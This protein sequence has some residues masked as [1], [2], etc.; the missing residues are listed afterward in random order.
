MAINFPTSLDVLV[1]P[2]PTDYLD[3]VPHDQ[4]HVLANDAIEALEAKL[5]VDSSAVATSI[6]YLVKNSASVDPGHKHSIYIVQA[7]QVVSAG[8]AITAIDGEPITPVTMSGNVT[9]TAAPTIAAGRNGQIVLI[10]NDDTV[11][12]LV[13]SDT[14]VLAG[15]LLRLGATTRTLTPGATLMLLYD[16]V[17]GAWVER[18]FNTLVS[19][20]P[21]IN[22]HTI[23]IGAGASNAQNAEVASSGTHTP[24]FAWTFTGVPSSGTVDVSAGGDP[25]TDYPA[26]ILTPFTSLVGPG[27]NKGTSVGTVR[28][29]TPTITVNGVPLSTPTATVTYI[30]RRYAG[31]NSQST[32]LSSAQVLGLD[33]AGG[34]SDLSTSQYGTFTVSTTT[35]EYVWF[36]HRSALTALASGYVSVDG[37]VAGFSDMGTLSHTNDSGFVETFRAYRSDYTNFGASKSVV[38]ASSLRNN[39]IYCGPSTDAD[40]IS[41]ANILALDDTAD[42]ES[43]VSS[44]LARTYT[45]IKIETAEYLWFCH[46]DRI[47]DLATIK[48][49]T[50]GFA[51]A[52]SYRTDVVHTNG[53]GYTE[54]YRCWRSDNTAIYPTGEDV[55]VT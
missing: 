22:S 45:A 55:V 44:T 19:I 2:L 14:G 4:Q 40:P 43:I 20:T 47:P 12:N 15:S 1:N 34:T 5:G 13:L 42:G 23:N 36:A 28:T 16:S 30:N 8:T 54:N 29:F 26:T 52:G 11:D 6:D 41:N 53:K 9:M 49:G 3:T 38:T 27:F 35:G 25:A 21:S 17:I 46:P 18:S 50:T 32:L 24:T 31:P 7:S 10:V 37:E 51:I 39:R 48:D 33:G